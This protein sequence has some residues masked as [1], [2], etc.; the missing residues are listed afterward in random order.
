MY[1]PWSPESLP[2][3]ERPG[4]GEVLVRLLTSWQ[5]TADEID[6]FAELLG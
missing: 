5:T 4:P 3:A 1:Y 2:V 6:R